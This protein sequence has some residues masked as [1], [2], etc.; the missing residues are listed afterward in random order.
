MSMQVGRKI[1]E[2]AQKAAP[3]DGDSIPIVD[4]SDNSTKRALVSSIRGS[5]GSG[6]G[7]IGGLSNVRSTSDAAD[8]NRRI[9][10]LVN[11]PTASAPERW[12]DVLIDGSIDGG[13]LKIAAD[14]IT[15]LPTGGSSG[16]SDRSLGSLNNVDGAADTLFNSNRYLQKEANRGWRVTDRIP[17]SDIGDIDAS[18]ITSGALPGAR[19]ANGAITAAK[20]ARNTITADRL[21]AGVIPGASTVNSTNDFTAGGGTVDIDYDFDVNVI[22]GTNIGNFA[23]GNQAPRKVTEVYLLPGATYDYFPRF[24]PLFD[25]DGLDHTFN[26][27]GNSSNQITRLRNQIFMAIST[28]ESSGGTHI[29]HLALHFKFY[30]L[31][32]TKS[33]MSY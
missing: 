27:F 2:L 12:Q 4:S 10:M 18:K 33:I 15:G 24:Q 28:G 20:I 23:F 1:S 22:R 19:I 7:T 11:L 14:S 30:A 21:A 17:G 31:T 26:F 9:K 32:A 13:F 16:P 5:G 3:A 25:N 6:G 8:S 29:S